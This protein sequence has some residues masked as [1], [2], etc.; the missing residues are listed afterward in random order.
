MIGRTISHYRIME[1]L[2]AGGMGEVFVAEDTSLGR[3][4]ALK[5][6]SASMAAD[7]TARARLVREARMASS[8]DHP[9]ICTIYEVGE[10]G[11]DT[12]IAMELAKGRSLA[13]Q[14]PPDGLPVETCLRRCPGGGGDR[15]RP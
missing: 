3:Q 2:G 14:I 15:A 8:L 11:G 12:F 13:H 9:H 4:V 1:R 7:P 6:V 10:E 5:L